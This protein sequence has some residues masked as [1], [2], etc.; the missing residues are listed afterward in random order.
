MSKRIL[1]FSLF[2]A[3]WCAAILLAS[4]SSAQGTIVSSPKPNVRI[5]VYDADGNAMEGVDVWVYPNPEAPPPP[6]STGKGGVLDVSVKE[7]TSFSVSIFYLAKFYQTVESY[8]V[9]G[10]HNDKAPPI[11][12]PFV[13][14]K[15]ST[16]PAALRTA[17]DIQ[18]RFT[19]VQKIMVMAKTAGEDETPDFVKG[20]LRNPKFFNDLEELKGEIKGKVNNDQVEALINATGENTLKGLV[21]YRDRINSEKPP[22]P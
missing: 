15:G 18:N 22:P 5:E 16:S 6:L 10:R 21:E 7:G 17:R 9:K 13:L 1:A 11:T 20:C 3:V 8:A 12:L 2:L 14:K 19:S 4:L